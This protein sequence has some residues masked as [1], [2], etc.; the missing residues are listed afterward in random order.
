MKRILLWDLSSDTNKHW[1]FSQPNFL[2]AMIFY[3]SS[4]W[5]FLWKTN[6]SLVNWTSSSGMDRKK[7]KVYLLFLT[8]LS[9]APYA[10]GSGYVGN[11]MDMTNSHFIRRIE[12]GLQ[13]NDLWKPTASLIEK[14]SYPSKLI[15][16]TCFMRHA[17]HQLICL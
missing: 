15:V 8:Y 5:N 2:E 1:L 10:T 16:Q 11:W 13:K 14:V 9:P 3:F 6:S 12:F 7:L 4:H 17:Q